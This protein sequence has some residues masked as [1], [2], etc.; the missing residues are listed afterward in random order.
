MSNYLKIQC[1]IFERP[2]IYRKV[3]Y[4]N[5]EISKYTEKN[6]ALREEMYNIDSIESIQK[7]NLEVSKIQT[8]YSDNNKIISNYKTL[9]EIEKQKLKNL[10]TQALV[11]IEDP[12]PTKNVNYKDVTNIEIKYDM[13][14]R[15]S[16]GGRTF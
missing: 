13:I 15:S 5:Q 14:S 1:D 7:R 16:S 10:Q 3:Q 9:I 4:L 6:D 8:A 11:G 2:D 12:R